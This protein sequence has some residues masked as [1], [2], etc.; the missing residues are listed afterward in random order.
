MDIKASYPDMTSSRALRKI[1]RTI[2]WEKH[3][4]LCGKITAH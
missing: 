1:G 4:V 3:S 2:M